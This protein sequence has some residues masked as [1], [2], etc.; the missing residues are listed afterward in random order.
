MNKHRSTLI[1]LFSILLVVFLSLGLVSHTVPAQSEVSSAVIAWGG[2]TSGQASVPL[3]LK[4][5]VAIA[6][7]SF[8]SLALKQDGSVVAWGCTVINTGQCNVPPGLN[9]VVA[10]S[11]FGNHSMALKNDGTVVVWG[12]YGVPAVPAGLSQVVAIEAGNSYDLALKEDGTVFTWG[13]FVEPH[14]I[15]GLYDVIAISNGSPSLALKADGTVV[16]WDCLAGQAWRCDV[17]PNLQGVTAVFAGGGYSLALKGDGTLAAWGCVDP[18]GNP[19]ECDLPTGLSGIIA[20]DDKIALKEDGTL[21]AWGCEPK[22][23]PNHCT[24]PAGLSGVT[25]VDRGAFHTLVIVPFENSLRTYALNQVLTVRFFFGDIGITPD[26]LFIEYPT[27]RAVS[28]ATGDPLPG[29]EETINPSTSRLDYVT[30]NWSY[31]QFAVMMEPGWSGT[32]R[33]ITIRLVHDHIVVK[34]FRVE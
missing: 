16:A 11:A 27:T 5:V 22:N 6:A 2:N 15:A 8:H 1:K 12:G 4:D 24:F 25:A 17:P 3:D 26:P 7:G 19:I 28:C 31:Y 33:R 14:V 30:S 21:V 23:P 9:G 18:K 13:R 29:S 20:I 34:Y 10:I 32:C